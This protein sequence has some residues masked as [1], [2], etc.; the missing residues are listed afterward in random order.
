MDLQRKQKTTHI[1]RRCETH[2]N[3]LTGA[4]SPATTARFMEWF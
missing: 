1:Q 4:R 3:P 2:F